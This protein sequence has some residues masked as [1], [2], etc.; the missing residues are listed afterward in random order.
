MTGIAIGNAAI[1]LEDPFGVGVALC[2]GDG[3]RLSLFGS[4]HFVVR[5]HVE[6]APLRPALVAPLQPGRDQKEC[7]I[8]VP[9]LFGHRRP[10]ADLRHEP[11]KRAIYPVHLRA[12][13]VTSLAAPEIGGNLGLENLRES[14]FD[15]GEDP[16]F[17]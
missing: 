11:R 7:A 16:M 4:F 2:P 9:E 15:G 14:C 8:F 10:P 6:V 3:V 5:L 17:D 13:A 1:A 12:F